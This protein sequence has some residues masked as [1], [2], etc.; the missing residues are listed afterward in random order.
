MNPESTFGAT[1]TQTCNTTFG[2]TDTNTSSTI[3]V[4]C[5]DVYN[6][7][8]QDYVIPSGTTID[9]FFKDNLK[10]NAAPK[11]FIVKIN[12]MNAEAGQ[13]LNP[14]DSVQVTPTKIQGGC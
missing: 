9:S 14:G 10:I 3:N 13:T 1:E 7:T 6:H 2:G 11:N 12:G 4:S 5:L 8:S